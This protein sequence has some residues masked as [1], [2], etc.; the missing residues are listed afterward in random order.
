[1]LLSLLLIFTT[2]VLSIFLPESL[3]KVKGYILAAVP[4]WL[5]IDFSRKIGNLSD[6]NSLT[7]VYA[8]MPKLGIDIFLY[9]DGLSLLFSLLILGIGVFVIIFSNDYMKSYSDTGKFYFFML[10]FMGAMLGLVLSA[11]LIILYLF[12]E[13]TSISSFFLIGFFHKKEE[14]RNAAIQALLV[15]ALGG[16]ALLTGIIL[17]GQ[18]AGSYDLTVILEN[19]EQILTSPHYTTILLLF[20]GG[21]LTKSA[22][23]PFH[24]WLPGAMQAPSPVSAYLHSATM[25]KA[26]VFLLFRMSSILGGTDQWVSIV[27]LFGIVTMFTGAYLAVTRTDLKAI[28]AFTTVSALGILTLLI[29]LDTQLSVKAAILFLV[30]HSLYKATLFMVAGALQKKTG[31]RNVRHLGGLFKRM[32]VTAT[33]AIISLLSMSGLPPMLGFIGKELIYEAKVQLGGLG[34]L[35]LILGVLSNVFLVWVSGLIAYRVFFGKEKKG[36]PRKMEP[37]FSLLVGPVLLS[38]SSLILGLAPG[39]FGE[40]IVEPALIASRIEILDVK[41]KLWH[42]FNL[43]FFLSL[44]TVVTGILFFFMSPRLIRVLRKI[45]DRFFSYNFSDAFFR[46][47]GNL[48]LFA[49]KNTQIIQ[50]GYHRIYLIIIFLFSASL[51]LYQLIRTW[52]WEVS[53]NFSD[54]PFYVIAIATVISISA[55]F[56][57][58][59][60]SRMAAI[61]LLGVTGYG[62]GLIFLI[63]GGID[64]AIT[65]I[66]VETLLLILFVLVVWKLPKFRKLSSGITRIRDLIVAVFMGAVITGVTLK[67]DFLNLNPSISQYFIEKSWPEAFGRNVVN[68]IL[69]DFRA[70]DT[71]GEITVL[72][73][74]AVGVLALLKMKIKQ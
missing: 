14:S 6:N 38:L 45:N 11:N 35:I 60:G 26:G 37:S 28:L 59:T 36:L 50:H 5:F 25:V 43:V 17:L 39:M 42:G 47:I 67:A 61:V 34:D 58:I 72:T 30:I 3:K 46:M 74:A 7:E 57:M 56:V 32:P 70:L 69:V 44:T 19:K 41:L 4:A 68:V 48:L 8:W 53:A 22:Q 64:L 51:I 52:G 16:L 13:L 18:V 15:T 73:L 63:Y 31:T 21:I 10:F 20:L 9:L 27:T 71:L 23:F 55:I 24:F 12:W 29:G 65:Q 62:I 49:K 40:M 2:A 66:I 1:M 33:A 54:M